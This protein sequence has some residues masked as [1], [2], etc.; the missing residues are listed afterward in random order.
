MYASYQLKSLTNLPKP[1]SIPNFC[2]DMNV[3]S[4]LRIHVHMADKHEDHDKVCV[5][6]SPKMDVASVA[7][8]ASSLAAAAAP[9]P[10][11]GSPSTAR[12]AEYAQ[13]FTQNSAKLR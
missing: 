11:K 3:S 1:I 7:P 9:L 10:A 4:I 2:D 12:F 5:L 8:L 6:C 13:E